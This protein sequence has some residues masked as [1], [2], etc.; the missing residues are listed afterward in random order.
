MSGLFWSNS[1]RMSD[2]T[3]L[4]CLRA[5]LTRRARWRAILA[6]ILLALVA[7]IAWA[8][9]PASDAAPGQVILT[10]ASTVLMLFAIVVWGARGAWSWIVAA[11]TYQ[12]FGALREAVYGPEWQ[13][14]VAGVL[15]VVIT[16][17][18]VALIVS[19]VGKYRKV[20]TADTP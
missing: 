4:P 6:G 2:S 17:M 8:L 7:T 9:T 19:Y 12:A 14:R 16:A 13:A 11:L 3:S 1:A 20:L 5:G 15:N 18:L 10:G